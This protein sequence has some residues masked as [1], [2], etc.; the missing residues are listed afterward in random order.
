MKAFGA[1]CQVKRGVV[2]S[3]PESLKVSGG[4]GALGPHSPI[5]TSL[6]R[7]CDS[8]L[9]DFSKSTPGLSEYLAYDIDKNNGLLEWLGPVYNTNE[10]NDG[11]S[12]SSSKSSNSSS[13]YRYLSEGSK[14]VDEKEATEWAVADIL[15]EENKEKITFPNEEPPKYWIR[16][17]GELL[18]HNK[19]PQPR[20]YGVAYVVKREAD[21]SDTHHLQFGQ[22]IKVEKN[23]RYK[24]WAPHLVTNVPGSISLDARRFA[25]AFVDATTEV[26]KVEWGYTEEPTPKPIPTPNLHAAKSKKQSSSNATEIKEKS[27]NT[28]K[29]KLSK[30]MVDRLMRAARTCRSR[31]GK[32][33]TTARNLIKQ[34]ESTLES[35]QGLR[36]SMRESK[37]F[38]ASKLK[39][40][41][42]KESKWQGLVENL[43][44]Q[45]KSV[46][47]L[48]KDE[49]PRCSQDIQELLAQDEA[50]RCRHNALDYVLPEDSGIREAIE[51]GEEPEARRAI[52][53]LISSYGRRLDHEDP[54]LKKVWEDG[55]QGCSAK[56]L[57]PEERN[58]PLPDSMIKMELEATSMGHGFSK[59]L[60]EKLLRDCKGTTSSKLIEAIL[61]N[62]N[63]GYNVHEWKEI[64]ESLSSEKKI[65]ATTVKA[66]QCEK[67][68]D[69]LTRSVLV[70]GC[71]E[72]LLEALRKVGFKSTRTESAHDLGKLFSLKVVAAQKA[73]SVYE[74]RSLQDS[75][76]NE[77]IHSCLDDLDLKDLASGKST[78]ADPKVHEHTA[79]DLMLFQSCEPVSS[80]EVE[81]SIQKVM[82]NSGNIE[83]KLLELNKLSL[84]LDRIQTTEKKPCKEA[85]ERLLSHNT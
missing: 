84:I 35:E 81:T 58:R 66:L 17:F 73:G 55:L 78:H 83:E 62:P 3:R 60:E 20:S 46:R 61:R 41:L 4:N 85:V 68:I 70:K 44:L 24:F 22:V 56:I 32:K 82:Q 31:D 15:H 43:R 1:N 11:S 63:K 34:M 26:P 79:E 6:Q 40:L 38:D 18:F 13:N 67:S 80:L 72:V 48:L 2:F 64:K 25:P 10:R 69:T 50:D 76:R 51:H 5:R 33:N 27:S 65:R 49:N 19:K 75:L 12:R 14:Q 23:G 54:R 59:V 53:T 52:S 8:S 9:E 7:C 37:G 74:L 30:L 45:L 36:K 21:G 16:P 57:A 42:D 47:D 29:E 71:R 39:P 28:T 77:K